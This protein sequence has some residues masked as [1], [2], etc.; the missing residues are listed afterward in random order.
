LDVLTERYPR[1]KSALKWWCNGYSRTDEP[2]YYDIGNAPYLKEYIIDHPPMFKVSNKCCEYAKKRVSKHIVSDGGFDVR[3]IG[4]RKAEG[5][6]RAKT[7][8]ARC[9][10][11]GPVDSY[12]PLFWF[13]DADKTAYKKL[14]SIRNSACYELWGFKRTGCI[15]CPYN[16]RNERDLQVSH[17]WEPGITRVARKVFAD[18]YEYTSRYYEFRAMRRADERGQLMLPIGHGA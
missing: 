3:V 5:G 1:C 13:S 7:S 16:R 14:F 11:K 12:Y 17:T 2:G 10:R 6:I 18:T 9:F 4:I 15:G 8:D